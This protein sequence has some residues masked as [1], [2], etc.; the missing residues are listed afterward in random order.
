MVVPP[1]VLA[2]LAY[3]VWYIF[4]YHLKLR[5]YLR[6]I[7]ALVIILGTYGF[8]AAF[9]ITLLPNH[10]Y[11]IH[12]F[13]KLYLYCFSNFAWYLRVMPTLLYTWQFFDLVKPLACPNESALMLWARQGGTTLLLGSMVAAYLFYC[14]FD[15]CVFYYAGILEEALVHE[16]S[17]KMATA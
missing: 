17:L 8:E 14:Y 13:P 15:A 7:L 4:K 16:Y 3:L 6:L 2:S 10:G 11:S 5:F 9:M 12:D 1:V